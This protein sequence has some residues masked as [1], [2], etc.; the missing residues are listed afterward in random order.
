MSAAAYGLV[1]VPACVCCRVWPGAYA[2]MSLLP[3]TAWCICLRTPLPS[4]SCLTTAQA[5]GRTS[6]KCCVH[7]A[8]P[9]QGCRPGIPATGPGT[10]IPG[11]QARH[12]HSTSYMRH[13]A[14]DQAHPHACTH[15]PAAP[16]PGVRAVPQGSRCGLACP[17]SPIWAVTRAG[18]ASCALPHSLQGHMQV[19][20]GNGV[21]H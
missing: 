12:T 1:H 14:A 16:H 19:Q 2:C 9:S 8:H 18:R 7:Q 13:R 4:A 5:V 15:H 17:P 6:D 3:H 20:A 11:L 10:P 21:T